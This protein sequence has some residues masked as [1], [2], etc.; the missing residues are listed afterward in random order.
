[1][2]WDCLCFDH[3]INFHQINE[4]KLEGMLN[5]H[6]HAAAATID[7]FRGVF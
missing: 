7:L 6:Q 5:L 4:L 1:M 2:P 3:D